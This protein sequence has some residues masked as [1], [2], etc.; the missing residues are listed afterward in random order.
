[1]EREQIIALEIKLFVIE[2]VFPL[3][4]F[5]LVWDYEVLTSVKVVLLLLD[6]CL[7]VL[8]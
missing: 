1:M 6:V 8:V 5:H 2:F 7:E 4:F 3:L